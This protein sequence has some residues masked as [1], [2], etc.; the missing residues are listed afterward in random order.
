MSLEI[1]SLSLFL[2]R[3]FF[4]DTKSRTSA[5]TWM[6]FKLLACGRMGEMVAGRC[7]Q[8]LKS[9]CLVLEKSGETENDMILTLGFL[10]YTN[11]YV[12]RQ[13]GFS[14]LSLQHTLSNKTRL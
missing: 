3:I 13:Q 1:P 6:H 5:V 14:V 11:F 2:I 8:A 4:S 12:Q 7:V 9:L 10:H